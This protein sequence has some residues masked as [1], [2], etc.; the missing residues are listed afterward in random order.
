MMFI[1]LLEGL[2][3][4]E[5]S[6]VCLAKDRQIGKR[7]KITKACVSEAFPEIDWGNRS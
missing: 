3:Q 1:Q 4:T 6:V 7:Y 5:A 2:H